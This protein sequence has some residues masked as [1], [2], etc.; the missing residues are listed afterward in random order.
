MTQAEM[1]FGLGDEDEGSPPRGGANRTRL[2]SEKI[3]GS[4]EALQGSHIPALFPS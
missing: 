3:E 1:A 4:A 2:R